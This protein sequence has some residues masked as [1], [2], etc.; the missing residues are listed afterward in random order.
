MTPDVLTVML[1][2]ASL[3]CGAI[4]HHRASRYGSK[5]SNGMAIAMRLCFGICTF[6]AVWCCSAYALWLAGVPLKI[7]TIE[8]GIM[9][10]Q[11]WFGPLC[12]IWAGLTYVELR[13]ESE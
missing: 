2:G 10:D 8:R 1:F 11:W 12:L 6:L 3:A 13:R 9:G 5:M 7:G 4:A